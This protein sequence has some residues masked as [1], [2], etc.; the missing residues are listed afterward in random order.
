VLGLDCVYCRV[1]LDILRSLPPIIL[2]LQ[3]CCGSVADILGLF[4][5]NAKLSANVTRMFAALAQ[6]PDPSA[7]AEVSNR[8]GRALFAGPEYAVAVL[9]TQ[10]PSTAAGSD[11]A[12]LGRLLAAALDAAR[13][14]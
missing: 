7:T 3:R 14:G 4:Y 13:M 9:T 10:V 1:G 2:I 12:R 8:F 6:S 5:E 11:Q